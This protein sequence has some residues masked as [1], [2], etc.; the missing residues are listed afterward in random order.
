MIH[1]EWLS[2]FPS[3]LIIME[4]TLFCNEVGNSL[5]TVFCDVILVFPEFHFHAFTQEM[6]TEEPLAVLLK[7]YDC[8]KLRN[9]LC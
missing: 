9:V 4:R 2:F 6:A 5:N 7:S 1:K 8:R 3:C